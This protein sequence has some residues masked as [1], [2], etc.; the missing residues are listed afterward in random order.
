VWARA[1]GGRHSGSAFKR[2][3]IVLAINLANTA[4]YVSEDVDAVDGIVVLRI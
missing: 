3:N 1:D 4:G 2:E